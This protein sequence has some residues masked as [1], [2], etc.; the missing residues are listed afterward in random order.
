MEPIVLYCCSFSRDVLRAKRLAE[1]VTAHNREKIPFYIS[2]PRRDLDLFRSTLAGHAVE[3]IAQEDGI[4]ANP[5]LDM[6]R[7]LA[8]PGGLQQQIVKSEF[9]R[10]GLAANYLCLDSEGVFIRDFGRRDFLVEGDVPY[11]IVHEGRDVLQATTRFGPHRVRG[12]FLADR[13][14]VMREM[15]RE[16]IVYDYGYSPYLWSAK[17]WQDLDRNFLKPRGETFADIVER[18]PSEFTWYGEALMKYRSI[19]LWPREQLFR[20][21]HYEHQYWLD[22]MLGMTKAVLAH[23]HMGIVFQ[24]NWETWAEYGPSKKSL[25]SR[26]GR[27]LKRYAR[28]IQ[29]ATRTRL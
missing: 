24:S 8:M 11:S 6:Q 3:L 9:W 18:C 2:V 28:R 20:H 21:Y 7:V 22:R 23:D 15:G 1:S 5:A 4:A 14:A 16:G 10:L 25:P 27:S 17:V 13:Q 29:F 19:P 26:L 12:E